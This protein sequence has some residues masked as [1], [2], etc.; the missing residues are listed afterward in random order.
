MNIDKKWLAAAIVILLLAF[1][2]GMKYQAIKSEQQ[3]QANSLVQEEREDRKDTNKKSMDQGVIQVY[4]TGQVKHPGVYR[5][6]DGDRLFQAVELAG[7][8][9]EKADLEHQNMAEKLVDGEKYDITAIGEAPDP[10][11]SNGASFNRTNPSNTGASHSSHPAG[12][13]LVNINTASL[14]ELDTLDGIGP[15]LAQRIIDYRTA[16]GPFRTIEDINN[17]SGIGDKKYEAIKNNITIR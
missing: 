5:L 3:K 14:A 2:G 8:T 12:G 6:N 9:L 1:A 11:A 15:T 4:V 7:G 17:V 16:N 10:V 13:G